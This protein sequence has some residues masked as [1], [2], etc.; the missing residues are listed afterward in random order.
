MFHASHPVR[1]GIPA[2]LV[3]LTLCVASTGHAQDR[4]T[5]IVVI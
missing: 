5:N 4:R 1:F 3:G 2:L